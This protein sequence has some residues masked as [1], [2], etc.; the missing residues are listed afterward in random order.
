ML[1][2]I[3]NVIYTLKLEFNNMI[4]KKMGNDNTKYELISSIEKFNINKIFIKK[5]I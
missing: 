2:K 5:N 4:A 1:E 3:C